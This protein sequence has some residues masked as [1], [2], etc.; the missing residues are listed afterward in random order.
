MVKLCIITHSYP[1]FEGDWRSNFI[2]SLARAYARNGGDVNVLVPF[3]IH[4]NR[5]SIDSE[6]VKIV[7]YKYMPITSLHTIGYGHSMKSD[8]EFNIQD[9]FL[10][11]FLLIVGIIRLSIL[12]R[13]DKYD[14]IHAHW[15]VPNTLIAV[16]GRFFRVLKQRYL[17]LFPVLMLRS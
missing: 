8:L 1:R 4:F 5:S 6:G 15:A 11:P 2:E 3:S 17:P 7:S 14:M 9:L 16:L 13:K 12:L 10:M